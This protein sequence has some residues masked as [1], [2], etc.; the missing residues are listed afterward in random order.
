MLREECCI[1]AQHCPSAFSRP[2]S[3]NSQLVISQEIR[4][5]G[6][7]NH[8]VQPDVPEDWVTSLDPEWVQLWNEH[9]RYQHRAD[10]VD[11]E[12]FRENP[13]QY[14]FTHPTYEGKCYLCYLSAAWVLIWP[15]IG[16]P[17]HRVEDIKVPVDKP[18]GEITVRL[19]SP[20]TDVA[21]PVHFN[22][23]GGGWVLG[24]LKSEQAWCKHVC[25]NLG[26]KV[27]DI[28]Y[29]M[30]PEFQFPVAIYDCW[31]AV[32]FVR[33]ILTLNHGVLCL[34][35]IRCYATQIDTASIAIV[36]P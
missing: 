8:P 32:K 6:G 35:A 17:V 3:F 10:E 21:V 1:N 19:Y 30:A 11:I 27:V 36:Y 31:A 14:S 13:S 4:R 28:D 25:N 20:N 29:R 18:E 24:G 34:T 22:M 23:H 33:L 26:I 7:G 2:H 12:A 15:G 5:M 9:G 16:P